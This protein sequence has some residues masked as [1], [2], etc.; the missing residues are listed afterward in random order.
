MKGGSRLTRRQFGARLT[1]QQLGS[2]E[3]PHCELRAHFVGHYLSALVITS[4]AT[5]DG[6]PR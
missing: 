5:G 2:W 6:H 4:A 3:A 1:A